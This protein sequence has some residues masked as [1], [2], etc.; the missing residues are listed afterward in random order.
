MTF[1]REPPSFTA[2]REKI[3][4]S[5][6]GI[7]PM[8]STTRWTGS[9]PDPISHWERGFSCAVKICSATARSARL[10]GTEPM[11]GGGDLSRSEP[12]PEFAH[13]LIDARA[14]GVEAMRD[15][16]LYVLEQLKVREHDAHTFAS[17]SSPLLAEAIR[18]V[19]ELKP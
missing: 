6:E 10:P 7:T 14:Q 13:S 5:I 8:P 17:I 4:T 18:K 11:I 3:A 16:C 1:R 12:S 2:F 19:S 9:G 15:A